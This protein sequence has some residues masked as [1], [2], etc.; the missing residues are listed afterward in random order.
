MQH[1]KTKLGLPLFD[2]SFG[3]IYFNRPMIIRGRKKI[4]K[5]VLATHFIGKTIK[6]GE[7]VLLFTDKRPDDVLLDARSLNFDFSSAVASGQLQLISYRAI[8]NNEEDFNP[9]QPLPFE[10]AFSDLRATVKESGI[11]FVVF[12]TVIPWLAKIPVKQMPKHVETFISLINQLELTSLLLMPVPTSPAAK[13]LS[14]K[15]DELCPIIVEMSLRGEKERYINVIKY[16]GNTQAQIPM[17]FLVEIL[18]GHG[19][20]NI[21]GRSEIDPVQPSNKNFDGGPKKTFKPLIS[22]SFGGQKEKDGKP[23]PQPQS[24]WNG[25]KD[26][27]KKKGVKPLVSSSF[28]AQNRPP[29][30]PATSSPSWTAT[31]IVAAKPFASGTSQNAKTSE[32]ATPKTKFS[33]VVGIS[34]PAPTGATPAPQS[35]DAKINFSKAFQPLNGNE[36]TFGTANSDATAATVKQP[37][38]SKANGKGV[39]FSNVIQ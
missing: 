8:S 16:Q 21:M 18:P 11:H 30:S 23:S 37:Q 12:D 6:S 26:N 5:S 35:K 19:I 38:Q 28:G 31:S 24:R 7:R 22:S 27:E 33:A 32:P 39:K 14:E 4:G 2:Q 36:M 13:A 20:T 9:Y 15:L 34:A 29:T 25:Q 10:E 17:E 3:G 1:N